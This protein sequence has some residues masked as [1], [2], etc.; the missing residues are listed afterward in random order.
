MCRQGHYAKGMCATHYWRQLNGYTMDKPVTRQAKWRNDVGYNMAH[1]RV[2]RVKG[3]APLYAC[4]SCAVTAM[5]W[6]LKHD[7]PLLHGPDPRS[8]KPRF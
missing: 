5:H 8:G 7:A 1:V 6:A 4:V 2:R 3:S